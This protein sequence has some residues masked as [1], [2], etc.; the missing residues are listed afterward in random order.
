MSIGIGLEIGKVRSPDIRRDLIPRRRLLDRLHQLIDRQLIVV[1]AGPGMGKT[2]LL[3]QFAGELDFPV[4]WY[5]IDRT[6][7]DVR[8][9]A[10]GLVS[11][12]QRIF[13]EFGQQMMAA[14]GNGGSWESPGFELAK[15]F[16][17]D[18]VI[19]APDYMA[20]FIDDVHEILDE[21]EALDFFETLTTRSP[22]GF[23]VILSSRHRF[24][25]KG[26]PRQLA[27][28]LAGS[29]PSSDLRFTLAEI[30][31]YFAVTHGIALEEDQADSIWQKTQGWAAILAMTSP[32]IF[33]DPEYHDFQIDDEL[34]VDY[35]A[36]EV[37]ERETEEHRDFLVKT[38]VFDELNPDLC[39]SV[40][41]NDKSLFLLK[42]V[43]DNIPL[44]TRTGEQ[45]FV[46]HS[47]LREYLI[48]Q[49][50]SSPNLRTSLH[51][52]GAQWFQKTGRWLDSFDHFLLGQR[53]DLAERVVSEEMEDL[54]AKGHWVTIRDSLS[55]LSKSTM[56]NNPK[57][58][59]ALSRAYGE[60]G[61]VDRHLSLSDIAFANFQMRGDVIGTAHSLLSKVMGLRLKGMTQ[62]ALE[63]SL[64]A[65][66][67]LVENQ[68]LPR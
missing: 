26:F 44:V 6:D 4:C 18:I 37:L 48:K 3:S 66:G 29:I 14:V 60:I 47:L 33:I 2:T 23:H 1:Q 50:D 24:T 58:I 21:P 10:S 28:R 64:K 32:E 13:P 22:Q 62:E 25:S 38:S 8:N 68:G 31:E 63:L 20:L 46:V 9:L 19:D 40:L 17:S 57:L 30:R 34:F 39:G 36:N 53:E 5:Q 55:K 45:S 56:E 42:E 51:L 49:L 61:D 65:L 16:L 41:A 11:S 35:L 59:L 12:L 52:K 27:N 7:R 15:A 67:A 54:I 43:S